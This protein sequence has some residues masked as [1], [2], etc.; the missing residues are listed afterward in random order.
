MI[1]PNGAES[2]TGRI[3]RGQGAKHRPKKLMLAGGEAGAKLED[4]RGG[5][6]ARGVIP[7]MAFPPAWQVSSARGADP[8][9]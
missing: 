9:E 1:A 7:G 2:M 3:P 5:L 6:K 4:G 8:K